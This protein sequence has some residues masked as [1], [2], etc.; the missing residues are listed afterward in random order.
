MVTLAV[1]DTI[2]DL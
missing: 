2:D 1:G